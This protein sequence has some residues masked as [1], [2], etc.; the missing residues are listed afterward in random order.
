MALDDCIA[1]FGQKSLERNPIFKRCF[2]NGVECPNRTSST[3][4]TVMHEQRHCLRPSE[5]NLVYGVVRLRNTVVHGTPRRYNVFTL[6]FTISAN[7]MARP[8]ELRRGGAAAFK[9]D[10]ALGAARNGARRACRC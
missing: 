2:L 8:A 1:Q 5:H 9:P 4:H 7:S 3:C 10:R 6:S